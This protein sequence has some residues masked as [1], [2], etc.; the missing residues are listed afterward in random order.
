[1]RLTPASAELRAHAYNP[2]L[3]RLRQEGCKFEA[4]LS[5]RVSFEVS[6]DYTTR[7]CLKNTK[8]KPKQKKT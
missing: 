8:N 6:L 1:M 3:Q 2:S 7:L 4:N 5:H